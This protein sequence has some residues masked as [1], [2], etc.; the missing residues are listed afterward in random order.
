MHT[1][2]DLDRQLVE[3]A[4]DR[5]QLLRV[6]TQR[7]WREREELRIANTASNLRARVVAETAKT[8]GHG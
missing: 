8:N 7:Q 5:K 2:D 6:G 3:L 4:P 1:T